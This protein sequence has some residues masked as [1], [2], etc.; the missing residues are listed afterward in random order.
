MPE[1]ISENSIGIKP[2]SDCFLR[3]AVLGYQLF[4]LRKE[5]VADNINYVGSVRKAG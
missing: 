2:Y 3:K 1:K 4:L 5:G